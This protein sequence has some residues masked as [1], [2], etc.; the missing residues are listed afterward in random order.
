MTGAFPIIAS[1]G[2]GKKG[3]KVFVDQVGLSWGV[4]L[5]QVLFLV[6]VP[7]RTLLKNRKTTAF[8]SSIVR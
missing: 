6:K 2:L 1:C 4:L 7:I 5:I 3:T 8:E